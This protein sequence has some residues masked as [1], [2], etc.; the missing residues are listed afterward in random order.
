[1]VQEATDRQCMISNHLSIHAETRATREEPVV[2][3]LL[4]AGGIGRG[5]LSIGRRH[6][7]ELL[8]CLDV[9]SAGDEFG[10]QPIEEFGM[11]RQFTLAAEVFAGLNQTCSKAAL[12]EPVHRDP[13][14][15]GIGWID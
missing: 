8:Q 6:H 3:I 11:R 15:E 12:P 9:P 13:S 4:L 2:E 14:R 5:A 1:M 7:D 10:G